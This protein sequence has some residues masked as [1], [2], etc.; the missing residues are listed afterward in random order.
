MADDTNTAEREAPEDGELVAIYKRAN[1][2]DTGKAQPLTTKRIINAM[3]AAYKAGRASLAASAG[4]EPGPWTG[5]EEW[6]QLAWHLCAEENGEES[7]DELI[8]EGGPIPEPWGPRW[9]KYEH[10]ATRMIELVR[11][12][13]HHSPPEGMAG[14]KPPATRRGNSVM[15]A[16]SNHLAALKAQ[17]TSL[18]GFLDLGNEVERAAWLDAQILEL[19][20][21]LEALAAPPTAQAEGWK[22]VPVVPTDEMCRAMDGI[23]D[24]YM[25]HGTN[26]WAAMIDAA[27]PLPASEAKE[28]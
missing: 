7:C 5:G 1:G 24:S 6:E 12:F 3:R 16:A 13:T 15:N 11:K 10:E 21:E 22:W 28:L 14:W 18:D 20:S 23:G 19:E 9:M 26:I 4:S 17:R 27:P 2:E 25:E 8:W